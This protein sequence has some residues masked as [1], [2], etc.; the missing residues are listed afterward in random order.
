MRWDRLALL[1]ERTEPDFDA[2]G[3]FHA[4]AD[5]AVLRTQHSVFRV[6]CIDCLDR[7]NVAQCLLARRALIHQ[8]AALG[9]IPAPQPGQQPAL[10]ANLDA[11]LKTAWA[12]N[13]DALS[14]Q[15]A[16]TGALKADFTRTGKR[17]RYGLLRDGYFSALRYAKN[18]FSDGWRQD[19]ID[20]LLGNYRPDP[21][22]P[23]PFAAG[24]DWKVWLLPSVLLFGLAMLLMG[25]MLPP[26][27]WTELIL[28]SLFWGTFV[29]LAVFGI[30]Y[31]GEDF[32]D[33]PRLALLAS[34]H[35][36]P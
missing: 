6:N 20:L 35:R 12:D 22:G 34:K 24:R 32:V 31:Y 10:A 21:A 11:A 29:V 26:E 5:G 8:L 25:M 7:T 36:R 3:Y 13:A 23:S 28:F 33:S 19:S 27:H 15:Y 16:G 4:S 9:W 30:F 1:L 18:N 14:L 2:M 17:T